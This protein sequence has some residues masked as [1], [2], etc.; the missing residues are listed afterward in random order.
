[1]DA[2]QME[3]MQVVIEQACEEF[4]HP[5]TQRR[6]EQVLL[7]FRRSAAPVAS[8][9]CRFILERSQSVEARFHAA[10]TLREAV[11]R[12]WASQ[13]PDQIAQIRSYALAYAAH[14]AAEPALGVV[15]AALNGAAAV[16]LKRGWGEMT[17]EARA[18]FFQARARARACEVEASAAP[19]AGGGAPAAARLRNALEVVDAVVGEFGLAAP[20]ALGLP[21]DYHERCRAE[22]EAQSLQ[23]LFRSALDVARSTSAAGAAQRGEDAGACAAAMAV[24]GGVLNW[25]VKGGGPA[26]AAARR[27]APDGGAA[28]LRP[29]QAWAELLL[30]DS[31][32][33]WLLALLPALRGGGGGGGEGAG[34]V[35]AERARQLVVSYCSLAG[36]VFPRPAPGETA[37]PAVV[38]HCARMLAA[39]LPWVCPAGP[40]VHAALGGDEGEVVDACRAL[41]A[42]ASNHK[43]AALAAAAAAAAAAPPPPGGGAAPPHAFG[44]LEE[45]TS[46]LLAAG[47]AAGPDAAEPWVA[48]CTDMLLGAWSAI[49]TPQCCYSR[50]PAGPPAGAAGCAA[51]VFAALVEA[52]LADAA[53][54]AHEDATEDEGAGAGAA[55]QD[56]WLSRAAALARAAPAEALALLADRIA[57][58]QRALAAAAGA[59]ADA[60]EVLEQLCWLA[61]MAAHA[62]ADT[63]AGETPLPPEALLLALDGAGGGRPPGGGGGGAAGAAGAAA[64]GAA[65]E[66]LSCALLELC[67]LCLDPAARAAGAVSPRLM[68]VA[69]WGG[70]RWADTYLFPD[71][72]PLPEP[73]ESRFGGAGGGG[74]AALELLARA[75]NECLTAY[76]GEA[77]LTGVVARELLPALARRRGACARLLGCEPWRALAAAFAGREALLSRA[78]P[79]KQQRALARSLCAAAGALGS[80]GEGGGGGGGQQQAGAY[81]LQ[82]MEPAA[83]EVAALAAHAP[84]Q[85]A[86]AAE[87]ADVQLQVC[88]LLETLRG[89][90][91]AT[92]PATQ[93][94]LWGLFSG[95]LAPLL[96]LHWAFRHQPQVVALLLKLADDLVE[97]QAHCLPAAQAEALLSWA[98][99]LL[100]QYSESNLWQ[101]SL[102]TAKALKDE[103]AAE[104]CRDLRA[105]LNLLLHVTQSELLDDDGPPPPRAAAPPPG[106]GPHPH[107]P[108]APADGVTGGDA[109]YDAARVVL[110]G[111]HIVLPLISPELL[112]FPKLGQLYYGLLSYL[113]EAHTAAVAALEPRHFASLMASLEWGLAG[114]DAAA[115]HSCLE[116]VAGLGRFQ[117]GA[118]QTG[119]PGLAAHAPAPGRSVAAHFQELLL[120]RLLLDDTPQDSMELASD[121][122][123]PLLLAEPSA[124][125]PLSAALAASAEAA[126]PG[127]RAGEAVAAG[128]AA[129]GSWLGAAAAEAA[130]GEAGGGLGRRLQRGFRQRMCQLAAEVRAFTK[131]H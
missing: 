69:L 47:G 13:A 64:A 3:Q 68:E 39:A 17:P 82:L 104:Q 16:M 23:Q 81:V 31:A 73:L 24:L 114:S 80:E 36:D 105:V 21:W 29:G 63:G 32:T 46:A 100:T 128:L 70:A 116:G 65:V 94:A 66:R 98:L 106:G 103:R 20:S 85:L 50:A 122:L 91:R 1:M 41:S 10:C 52:A 8:S 107:S 72:G 130:G 96:Q 127:G 111:L 9:S 125:Q 18:A 51:R 25:G 109:R 56:E 86:A 89:A 42:L 119:A 90:A 43:P 117:L 33:D 93:P 37:A 75:A 5:A 121:A 12:E 95:L 83:R 45:L 54:G 101:V 35:L 74:Q 61:R 11:V 77:E 131:S 27:G 88:C 44:A 62:L 110:V 60:S 19:G 112:K 71:E 58:R 15:R 87:R 40:A 92:L 113:L 79:Q 7:Q 14:H 48:E 26:A 129:L 97:S 2:H 99:K 28:A 118:A 34:G 126:A 55:A 6:A 84:P 120:R 102:Q 38:G 78:L 115:A 76:P 49:L 67:G 123:L 53:A 22:L 57:D 30:A 124:F 108:G 4:K 59:G